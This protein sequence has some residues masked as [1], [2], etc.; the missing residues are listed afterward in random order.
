MIMHQM[1]HKL[2]LQLVNPDDFHCLAS[3]G[4]EV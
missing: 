2:I 3:T 4:A 1:C